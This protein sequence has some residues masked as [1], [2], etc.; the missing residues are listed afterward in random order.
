TYRVWPR[1]I[2]SAYAAGSP[3]SGSLQAAASDNGERAVLDR[4]PVGVLVYRGDILLH[5]NRALLEWTAFEDLQAIADAGGLE[6]LFAEPGI[7][8]LGEP[9]G[10]GQRLAITTRRGVSL[11]VEGRLF[12]V[13]W[14]G[15]TALLIVLVRGEAEERVRSAEEAVRIA[16]TRVKSAEA[17]LAASE[18]RIKLAEL[19]LRSAQA[20]TRELESILETATD[21][22]VVVDRDGIIL[23]S[24]RSAEALFGQESHEI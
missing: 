21:G 23:S 10:S 12:A 24:N 2:P 8:V 20:A 4:L 13:P 14:P 15:G 5:A 18:D 7:S 6:R 16:D 17:A 3:Q 1:P 11:P 19:G 22:V 9:G